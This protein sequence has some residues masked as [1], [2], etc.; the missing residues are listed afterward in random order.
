MSAREMSAA[1]IPMQQGEG[2]IDAGERESGS[3][4]ERDTGDTIEDNDEGSESAEDERHKQCDDERHTQFR[5]E[6]SNTLKQKLVPLQR[7]FDIQEELEHLCLRFDRHADF[8]SDFGSSEPFLID[9]DA[10][11]MH[12]LNNECLD[13]RN[14]GQILHHMYIVESF[15]Q[16]L[17]VRGCQ[18]DIFFLQGNEPLFKR[19]SSSYILART[20]VIHRLRSYA[21]SRQA[22]GTGSFKVHVI[23]GSWLDCN[24]TDDRDVK[25]SILV[26]DAG[27]VRMQPYPTSWGMLLET[28][29]PSFIMS[30][31]GYNDDHPMM[32]AVAQMTFVH[33][34]LQAR[35]SNIIVTLET[36]TFEGSRIYG[37]LFY[38][39]AGRYR[40]ETMLHCYHLIRKRPELTQLAR[41]QGEDTQ[42][43]RSSVQLA[44]DSTQGGDFRASIY[45][46]ALIRL[47]DADRTPHNRTIGLVMVSIACVGAMQRL[48]LKDRA[49][50]LPGDDHRPR[51][52]ALS[53]LNSSVSDLS[54]TVTN[55]QNKLCCALADSI[56]QAKD[57]DIGL[58]LVPMPFCQDRHRRWRKTSRHIIGN[59]MDIVTKSDWMDSEKTST[60]TALLRNEEDG[61]LLECFRGQGQ[62]HG[63]DDTAHFTGI[64][65]W[66]WVMEKLEQLSTEVSA[67]GGGGQRKSGSDDERGG[68]GGGVGG[69]DVFDGR[70]FSLILLQLVAGWTLPDWLGDTCVQLFT[71]V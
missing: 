52:S 38:P 11:I 6:V 36:L 41:R 34:C 5:F 47:L 13:W 57:I 53:F 63:H 7:I 66:K 26:E 49:F 40:S 31:A 68:G 22:S 54:E 45:L 28:F 17:S 71:T 48:S 46:Q 64:P 42:S 69:E 51:S 19:E 33:S 30:Y 24:Y 16:K 12:A 43:A 65:D 9:G 44:L 62:W 61:K 20:V 27:L 67:G 37:F 70:L 29:R 18:F 59:Y 56:Q 3:H 15:L 4:D 39:P 35:T 21:A 25:G 50:V 32:F 8:L 55:F 14:G 60:L 10:L 1:A 2:N 58:R 23:T